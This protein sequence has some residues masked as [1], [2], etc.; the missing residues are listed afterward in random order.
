MDKRMI[1]QAVLTCFLSVLYGER[2]KGL[3]IFGRQR[4]GNKPQY[5]FQIKDKIIA[6]LLCC[7]HTLV[8]LPHIRDF[9]AG[10]FLTERAAVDIEE[11]VQ[12]NQ[13]Q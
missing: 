10:R 8:V 4:A 1:A 5:L 11:N 12:G 6:I 9:L 13:L 7:S 3:L 2:W